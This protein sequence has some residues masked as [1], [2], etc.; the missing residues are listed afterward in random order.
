MT[1]TT[2]TKAPEVKAPRL[3]VRLEM[4]ERWAFSGNRDQQFAR[5][6]A[7]IEMVLHGAELLD[8]DGNPVPK[9]S[10]AE[11][12]VAAKEAYK[13]LHA[14]ATARNVFPKHIAPDSMGV[15]PFLS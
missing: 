14:N 1:M 11:L 2:K 10:K 13:L 5:D 9:P 6:E 12:K 7:L 4:G 3:R 8:L 15:K